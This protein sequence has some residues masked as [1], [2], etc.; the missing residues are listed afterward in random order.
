M[1]NV[2]DILQLKSLYIR[3]PMES[4]FSRKNRSGY[5]KIVILEKPEDK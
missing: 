1:A 2:I 5:E 3:F 4:I